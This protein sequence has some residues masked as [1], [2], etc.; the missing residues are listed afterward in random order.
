MAKDRPVITTGR[1]LWILLFALLADFFPVVPDSLAGVG[2]EE[3]K[4]KVDIVNQANAPISSIMQVRLRNTYIPKFEHL[5]GDGNILSVDITMP[6]PA[7]RI[8][9]IRHLT[10]VSLPAV[11]TNPDNK[12][13]SG[14]L[15]FIDLAILREK[16]HFLLAAGPV[17]IFP[18]ASDRRFGQQKW[19]VGPAGGF[20]VYGGRWLGGVLV[21]N[22]ISVGGDAG[23]PD[24]NQMFMQ[25]F[26]SCDLGRGWFVRSQPQFFFNWKTGGRSF[27][28]DLGFGRTFKIGPQVLSCY[29][30]PFWNF[31][32][33]K[34]T[35]PRNGITAGI[36]LL[37]PH[38]WEKVSKLRKRKERT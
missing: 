28:V 13:G 21:Q 4:P 37:Y 6:L 8:L 5:K 3:V 27:P 25:P 31:N 15:Q 7:H 9:P 12:T 23:R 16:K 34:G 14:D 10:R 19:Q 1:Y 18:T 30:Q 36:T 29:V 35:P 20:A 17:L 32:E 38:F 11:V 24:V 22:P 33:G 26:V 2:G